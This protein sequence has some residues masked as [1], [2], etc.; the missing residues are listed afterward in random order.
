MDLTPDQRGEL[1]SA[2]EQL[3]RELQSALEG[4]AEA[5]RP[6]QLDQPTVGRVSRID[7][8]QQQKMLQA[9]RS[10]QRARLQQVRSALRRFDED[11]YGDCV[12]CGSEIGHARLTASPEAFLCIDCQSARER[13]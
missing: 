4:S 7:A 11:E 9:N 12:S 3:E 1:R 5:A 13:R 2:L 8:V 6:V 10:G